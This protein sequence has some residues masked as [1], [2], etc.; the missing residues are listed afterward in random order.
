MQ[1]ARCCPMRW[2]CWRKDAAGLCQS[3]AALLAGVPGQRS[4]R[5]KPAA[6]GWQ[7]LCQHNAEGLLLLTGG[8]AP[9][10]SSRLLAEGPAGQDAERAAGGSW[11]EAYR[12]TA[13]VVELHRHGL[14]LERALEPGPDCA[15]GC[16]AGLPLVATNDCMSSQNPRRSTRRMMRLLCIAEQRLVI[17]AL[18]AAASRPNTGSNRRRQCAPCSPTCRRRAT[19]R[20]RSRGA[21][22]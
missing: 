5:S 6:S 8:P 4:R 22:R 10:R 17:G 12:R 2:W 7:T 1:S 11:S 21:V 13:A 9:A 19:T 15:G 20:W 18:S 16:Q 3:A 14:K